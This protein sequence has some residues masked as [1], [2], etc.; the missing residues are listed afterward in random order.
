MDIPFITPTDFNNYLK[1]FF[2]SARHLSNAGLDS[3]KNSAIPEDSIMVTCIGSDMGKVAITLV[4]CVTN[5]QI[6]SL[7]LKEEFPFVEFAYHFL[8]SIYSLL[9]SMASSGSTMPI[10]NK[11]DFE[12]IELQIPSKEKLNQFETISASLSVKIKSNTIQIKTL[13]NLRDTLLPKLMSGEV[14]VAMN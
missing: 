11:S 7:V 1:Y 12:N 5:Q 13:T 6:N 8:K 14:R 4:P 3:I 10:L 9:R 2:D